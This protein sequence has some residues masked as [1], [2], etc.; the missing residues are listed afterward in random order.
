MQTKYKKEK[1]RTNSIIQSMKSDLSEKKVEK[2]KEA[3]KR[4]YIIFYETYKLNSYAYNV[5]LINDI[6]YNEKANIVA[7]F[8]D[9]LIYDDSSEF[10]K[11][12]YKLVEAEDR[13]PKLIIMKTIQRFFQ[14]ILFFQKQNLFTKTFKKS[15]G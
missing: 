10:L 9:F 4:T 8:K 6:V 1:T 7:I 12:F 2:F 3:A 13:L 5:K 15:K 14:I 11:R